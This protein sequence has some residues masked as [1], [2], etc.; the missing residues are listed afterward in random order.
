MPPNAKQLTYAELVAARKSCDA[1]PSLTNPSQAYGGKLDS[2]RIGPYTRWQGNLNSPVIVVGQDFADVD[3]FA[4]LDGWPGEVGT[5]PTNKHLV[6]LTAAAGLPIQAPKRHEPDDRLFFTNAI[7]C[8]KH[9][10]MGSKVLEKC[11]RNCGQNFLC[12]TIKLV[13]PR[14]VVTL[15]GLALNATL[16][17][18]G[19][20]RWNGRLDQLIDS[21]QTYDLPCDAVLFPMYHPSRR[22]LNNYRS[23][24]QQKSDW[25]RFGRWL[26]AA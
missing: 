21:D 9:G 4:K 14:A 16:Q 10:N 18:F 26:A 19:I 3:S 8:L 24:D 20:P 1:C 13:K 12:K 25:A 6:E 2:N 7:L 23:L 22:V 5:V 17:S 15:G 11:S